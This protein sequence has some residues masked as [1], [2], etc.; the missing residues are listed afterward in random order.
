MPTDCIPDLFGFV[1]VEGRPV[2]AAFDGGMIT[3]D[4][5][6]LLLGATD[7]AIGMIDRFAACFRDVRRQD[8]IEHEVST[9]VGQRVFG[10]AL[11]YEDL[12][13]HDQLRHDPMM[14]VLAIDQLHR[15]LRKVGRRSTRDEHIKDASGQLRVVWRTPNWE[16]FVN[17]A[18]AEIR[19]YGAENVQMARRLRATLENL[20]QTLPEHRHPALRQE[21]DLLDRAIDRLYAFPEDAAIARVADSQGLGAS[22]RHTDTTM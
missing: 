16:D 5:G 14:A 20:I 13:D 18:V 4:A 1:A 7:R 11:G 22:G 17:L 10:L 2:V 3:S 8:R 19:F 21:L 15:L 6:G 9:L 12:N